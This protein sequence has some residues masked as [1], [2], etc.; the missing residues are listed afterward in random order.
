MNNGW[1]EIICGPMFCGKTEELIR[2]TKRG[3]DSYQTG[4]E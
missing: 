3:I 2:R 4:K 1:I